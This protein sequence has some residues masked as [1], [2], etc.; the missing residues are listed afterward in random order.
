MIPADGILLKG[1][2]QVD[3]SFVTG[4]ADPIAVKSGEQ[5]Y[6]GGKQLGE[7]IEISLTRKVSTSYL[8]QLWNDEAFKAKS[9]GHASA[10]ADRAGRYFTA[11]I[12]GVAALAFLWWVPQDMNKAINA[13][14]AV[15]IIACPC[16]VALSIPFTLGNILRILGR[17]RLYVK[18][19]NVLEALQEINEV[20]LDKT[21]TITNIAQNAVHFLPSADLPPQLNAQE[22]VLVKSLVRNSNHPASRQ[23]YESLRDVPV[24]LCSHF[25]ELTGQGIRGEILGR[26]VAIGS[27]RFIGLDAANTAQGVYVKIANNVRGYFSLK[28]RY[29]SGL[30]ALLAYFRQRQ[31]GLW[32]LSGDNDREAAHLQKIFEQPEQLRF[33]QSPQDKLEFVRQLHQGGKQVLMFGDGLNDA[34]ALQQSDVGIVVTEN[35][36]NF[37]PACDAI[38]H[39]DEFE[40]LPKFLDLSRWGVLT[41]QRA[42]LLAAVYNVIGL[43][44]AVTGTLSP[45]VAAILMP[46]SSVTIVLFGVGMGSWKS[47]RLGLQ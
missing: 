6:A 42:Y 27:S 8:T 31:S 21:G 2:A 40:R 43:S 12:L 26:S 22:Q 32:L 20:V 39:A 36:N 23:I 44:Y 10:L 13:F 15:L 28:S 14:T 41:V 35:T 11:L 17:N 5:I 45:V 7:P 46:L 47:W 16:A 24:E 38:L 9:R 30:T 3:Y 37:T 33:N 29:R 1:K 25:E 19:T 34:G 4:E 18:N